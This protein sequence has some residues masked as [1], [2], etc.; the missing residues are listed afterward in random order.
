MLK[1]FLR[2]RALKIMAA[3][4][5]DFIIGTKEDP[6]L[7]RWWVIPRNKL[8]NI[9]LHEIVRDDDDRAL[10]DHPWVNLSYL[11]EGS[12]TEVTIAAGGIN[13]RAVLRAGDWRFRRST[14]AHR[15]ELDHSSRVLSLFITGPRIREWGFHCHK[16]WRHFKEFV[17][18]RDGV[19]GIG[20]GCGELD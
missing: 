9:Y 7:I 11:L 10:H 3:R 5:P 6:Y 18:I 2:R 12:Y 8:F 1:E 16:G 20:A 17:A 15:L 13:H 14:A 4:K 19:S